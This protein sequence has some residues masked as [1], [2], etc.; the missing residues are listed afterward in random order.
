MVNRLAWNGHN[1]PLRRERMKR[2]ST[3]GG[4]VFCVIMSVVAAA[5]MSPLG[6]T[7]HL[8]VD[9]EIDPTTIYQWDAGTPD[10]TT[11]TLSVTGE[12]EAE[13]VSYPV[14]VMLVIDRSGSMSGGELT[15]AKLAAKTF[16]DQLK[17]TDQSGLVSFGTDAKLEQRLTYDHWRTKGAIDGL[18]DG[19]WTAMGDGIDLAQD[20]IDIRARSDSAHV[21]IVLSDG[22]SNEGMDPIDAADDAKAKGTVIYTIGLGKDADEDVLKQVATS[23]DHYYYAPDANDLIGIYEEISEQMSNYAGVDVVVSHKLQYGIYYVPLSFSKA[24]TLIS[25][26]ARWNVGNV[27]IGETW[28]VTF[29]VYSTSCGYG[30]AVIDVPGS[31][32]DYKMHD[33][34]TITLE[35]PQRYINVLCPILADFTWEPQIPYEGQSVQFTDTTPSRQSKIISWDW[36][37]GDGSS[38]SNLQNPTHIYVDD[39][40]Y[41]VTMEVVYEDGETCNLTESVTIKNA[42]P[43]VELNMLP[44]EVGMFLRIAGEKWHDV[45]IEMYENNELIAEGNLTRYPGS[46]NRQM[47]S[48]THLDVEISRRYEAIVRY[49][50][51]DDPVN[52]QPNGAT[53]CWIILNFSGQEEVW[54]HHTFNVQHPETYLWEVDLT[55]E[56]FSHGMRFEGVVNEPGA[57]DLTLYWDLGD[58]TSSMSFYANLFGTCPVEIRETIAHSFP[59]QGAY[60]VTLTAVDDDGG[61]GS[62]SVS[63]TFQRRA[64]NVF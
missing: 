51:E 17:P 40:V 49:T 5:H 47:L 3:P 24:P 41:D 4:L 52:G 46:P 23:P 13:I 35:F 15:A 54:L 53:P 18:R 61:V 8:E 63:L 36:D 57:D 34:A 19:G 44:T 29:E 62:A 22:E 31:G 7:P 33:G 55:G 21:M 27:K 28:K 10:T 38:H 11:V 6:E 37:F 60:I 30:M 58:G 42:P 25:G 48:L 2:A 20:E 43:T 14:D 56:M 16:V 32:V 9:M 26:V 45:S 59:G 1:G 50:P 64:L 39:D 12:G